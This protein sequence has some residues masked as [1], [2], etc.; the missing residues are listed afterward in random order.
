[1]ALGLSCISSI[2]NR[3]FEVADEGILWAKNVLAKP[4]I[5]VVLPT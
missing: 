4:R 5:N 1:M 2:N 3:V